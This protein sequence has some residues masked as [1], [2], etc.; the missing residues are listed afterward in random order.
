ML[1]TLCL[2][3][4]QVARTTTLK[5]VASVAFVSAATASASA[6][7]TDLQMSWEGEELSGE[8]GGGYNIL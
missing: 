1:F 4:G 7:E 2:F 5:R 8:A 3:V 6:C